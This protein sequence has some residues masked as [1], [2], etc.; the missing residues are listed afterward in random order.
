MGIIH[1]HEAKIAN[2]PPCKGY[3]RCSEDD[4]HH[5]LRK[6][7]HRIQNDKQGAAQQRRCNS[8]K[9]PHELDE[10]CSNVTR[11]DV[12]FR[13]LHP[14]RG[15]GIRCRFGNVPPRARHGEGLGGHARDE[16]DH[17]H[18]ERSDGDHNE[19]TG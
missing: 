12:G 15:D 2:V 4:F 10:P 1:R 9:E 19:P 3:F 7:R 8:Q 13:N 14:D 6:R 17:G 11:I 18:D 16:E 5:L